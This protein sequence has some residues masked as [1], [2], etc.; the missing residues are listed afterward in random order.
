MQGQVVFP[1]LNQRA[2]LAQDAN[3]PKLVGGPET[4]AIRDGGIALR[5]YRHNLLVF[6]K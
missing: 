1:Q 6:T 3:E 4:H 5:R 2:P